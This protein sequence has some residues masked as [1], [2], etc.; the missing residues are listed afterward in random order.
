MYLATVVVHRKQE[1][2][3]LTQFTTQRVP[4]LYSK[5]SST[6]PNSAIPAPANV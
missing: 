1:G 3:D 6:F 5:P 4:Y 2:H